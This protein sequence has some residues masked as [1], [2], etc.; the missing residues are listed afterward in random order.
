MIFFILYR[1]RS[2]YGFV[3]AGHSH[4]FHSNIYVFRFFGAWNSF[5]PLINIF[6]IVNLN[7]NMEMNESSRWMAMGQLLQRSVLTEVEL[8][9]VITANV[10]TLAVTRLNPRRLLGISNAWPHKT[11]MSI[12]KSIGKKSSLNSIWQRKTFDDM[13]ILRVKLHAW[14]TPGEP[15]MWKVGSTLI[16][17]PRSS[18]RFNHEKDL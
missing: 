7:I 1:L 4:L 16:L 15:T 6:V 17:D 3:L 8:N 13:V 9:G 12:S 5:V 11:R 18:S 2:T 10:R 14:P